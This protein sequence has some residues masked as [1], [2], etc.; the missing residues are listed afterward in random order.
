MDY[1]AATTPDIITGWNVRFFDIPYLARRV[2]DKLGIDQ[3][4]KFSPWRL[5]DAREITKRNKKH[6]V[7]DFQGVQCLD[8]LELFQKFGYSYGPQES[9]KLNH[10][11]NV[12]LGEK[13]LSYE[14]FGSL[15]NL[16]KENFS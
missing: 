8:Y 14:E 6:I 2:T 11:A 3:V 15:K 4:R 1:W 9:Y 10:I 16:H 7:W 13:K 5:I 12:V